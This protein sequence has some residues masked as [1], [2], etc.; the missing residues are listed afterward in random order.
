MC[1]GLTASR[2]KR[3][4]SGSP[5]VLGR[6]PQDPA[7]QTVSQALG[8][9][10][11]V[12]GLGPRHIGQANRDWPTHALCRHQV[13]ARK[14]GKHLQQAFEGHILKIQADDLIG[15]GQVGVCSGCDCGNSGP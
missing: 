13:Q 6:H 9:Q 4:F 3:D 2:A 1:K 10:H 12:Q 15:L 11:D 5:F 8:L 14:I 7:I